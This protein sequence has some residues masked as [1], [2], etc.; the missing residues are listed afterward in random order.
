M[1]KIK[2]NNNNDQTTMLV[3]I[4]YRKRSMEIHGK[5]I[6]ATAQFFKWCPKVR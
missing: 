5:H 2:K 1:I 6:R 3:Y 4:K